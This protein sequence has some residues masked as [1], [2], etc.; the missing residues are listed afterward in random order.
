VTVAVVQVVDVVAVLHGFVATSLAVIVVRAGVLQMWQLAL[1]PVPVMRVVGVTVVDV[2][3]VPIVPRRLTR[4]RPTDPPTCFDAI[5][6]R[7][8]P[9]R[10]GWL[11]Q[12]V[13]RPSMMMST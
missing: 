8:S 2:I 1:V 5:D 9:R 13:R 3:G 10:P 11:P 12:R 6:R 4:E 7:A